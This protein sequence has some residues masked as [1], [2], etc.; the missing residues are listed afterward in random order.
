MFVIC[1]C[2]V[3]LTLLHDAPVFSTYKPNNEKGR[4]NAMYKGAIKWNQLT[5]AVRNLGFNGFKNLQKK[6]LK[7]YT[8]RPIYN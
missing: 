3:T 1:T 8:S 7:Y 2:F 6:V 4:N 5:S